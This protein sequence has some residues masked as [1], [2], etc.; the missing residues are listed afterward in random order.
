VRAVAAAGEKEAL[1]E[2]RLL[3]YNRQAASATDP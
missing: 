1:A 2:T 3:I